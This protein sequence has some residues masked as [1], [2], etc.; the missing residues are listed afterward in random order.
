MRA[1]AIVR[2]DV[3]ARDG[4]GGVESVRALARR[5]R[6]DL[7][8][9]DTYV[10]TDLTVLLAHLHS[11]RADVVVVPSERH[12]RGWMETVRRIAAVWTV[13]P[14]MCWPQGG[15]RPHSLTRPDRHLQAGR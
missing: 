1:I 6:L 15:G 5:M 2:Q 12:L 13:D 10:T 11:A 9:R 7:P 3:S 8:A 14:P 4:Q